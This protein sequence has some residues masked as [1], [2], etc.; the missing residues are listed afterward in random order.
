MVVFIM[1]MMMM[2]VGVYRRSQ[3][4]PPSIRSSRKWERR[5]R[6]KNKK[7]SHHQHPTSRRMADTVNGPSKWVMNGC[8]AEEKGGIMA[9]LTD[10]C[11]SSIV[12]SPF[13]LPL[14]FA[15]VGRTGRRA[16]IAATLRVVIGAGVEVAGV[17]VGA[18]VGVVGKMMREGVTEGIAGIVVGKGGGRWRRGGTGTSHL[19]F[20]TSKN[21]FCLLP[22]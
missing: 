14:L 4:L 1:M 8:F 3:P 9:S 21:K 17:G 13:P 19:S 7:G 11:P 15:V 20:W 5:G 6:K 22:I 18:A 10:S 12:F 2:S 16:N